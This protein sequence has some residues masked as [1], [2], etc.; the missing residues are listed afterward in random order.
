MA[1]PGKH[2]TRTRFVHTDRFVVAVDVDAVIPDEDPS[3][4]CFEPPT[5]EFLRQVEL[6][7]RHDDREWLMRHGRVYER[8]T[9]A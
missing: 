1:I 4:P 8:V 6:H 5:V 2:V 9:A 7:A 3:E